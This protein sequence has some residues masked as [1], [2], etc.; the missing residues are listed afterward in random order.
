L[1]LDE[2]RPAHRGPPTPTPSPTFVSLEGSETV[3]GIPSE[4]PRPRVPSNPIQDSLVDR[5]ISHVKNTVMTNSNNSRQARFN[6]TRFNPDWR[7][8]EIGPC[9][10]T[11]GMTAQATATRRR[12]RATSP[13]AP[14]RLHSTENASSRIF[15]HLRL[16]IWECTGRAQHAKERQ[17]QRQRDEW[18]VAG[19]SARGEQG[20]TK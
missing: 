12:P 18:S 8:R 6:P 17:R 20:A 9:L 15:R 3:T 13:F 5:T 4:P 19:D 2:F 11:M 14:T 7:G 16:S 1:G 10:A